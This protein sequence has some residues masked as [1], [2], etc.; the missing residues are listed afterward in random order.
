MA[1][2]LWF[3]FEWMLLAMVV[4]TLGASAA[5]FAYDAYV[6]PRL[7]PRREIAAQAEAVMREH[8]DDPEGWALQEELAA[9]HRSHGEERARWHRVRREIRRRSSG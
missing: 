3:G 4:A 8:P 5:W 9:W 1:E 6:R 7:I 2:W